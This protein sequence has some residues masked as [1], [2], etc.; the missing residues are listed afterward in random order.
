MRYFYRL[1]E[2][3]RVLPLMAAIARQ[4]QLWNQDTL[5]QTFD[6]SPHAQVDDILL[7][8]SA[9]GEN[10]GDNL[11]AVD[12]DAMRAL[13]NVKDEILNVMR[14]V[15]GSRL[16]RVIITKLEPGKKIAPHSDQ[17]GEYAK[18]YTRY[19]LVLQ[20]MPGSLFNCGDETVCMQ[21]GEL[22]WF[23][24]SAEHSVV[25][26]SKDDRIHMLIDVRIDP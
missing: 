24:A 4:P 9:P 20:G 13:P 1:A 5:R 12:R 16:G 17:L 25:N 22:W 26:N 8:F 7:R 21:T 10:V 18:Y 19:H 6:K 11:E 14:V 23:D 15:G 2:G 3:I